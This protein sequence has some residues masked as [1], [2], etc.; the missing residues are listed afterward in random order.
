MLRLAEPRSG[1]RSHPPGRQDAGAPTRSWRILDEGDGVAIFYKFKLAESGG[2]G[3]S[4]RRALTEMAG[5]I[6]RGETRFAGST[7]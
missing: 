5:M 1:A 6:N 4:L 2:E 7:Q 3:L